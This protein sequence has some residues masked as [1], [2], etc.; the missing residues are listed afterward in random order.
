[1][2]QEN[3]KSGLKHVLLARFKP[4]ISEEE[5]ASLIAGYEALPQSIEAMKG[6]EWGTDV[7]VE[8]LH[9][10][11]TH[12]F[13]STFESPEGR[14][15]YLVHPAHTAYANKLLPALDKV[16]VLDFHP[17]VVCHRS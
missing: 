4:E 6:F 14:D 8:N 2:A 11:F 3:P 16:I 10:D 13:T 12:V 17:K 15:A 7:S 9:Q 5:V 1:M